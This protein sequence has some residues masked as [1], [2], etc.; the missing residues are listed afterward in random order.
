[1]KTKRLSKSALLLTLCWLVYS[2]SYI[3][4]LSYN[5]NINQIIEAF[6]VNNEQAGLVSSCFFF[7]YGIGQVVNG[8][9]CKKY[10]IKY[11]I[12][13]SLIVA[14]GMNVLAVTV[15]D[16]NLIKYIWLINGV[17]MSFLWTSLIRLLS[18]TVEKSMMPTVVLVM[19][20]TVAT[21]TFIV[22]GI[23]SM[24][25][26]LFSY[27]LTFYVAAGLMSAVALLWLLSYNPLVNPLRKERESEESAVEEAVIK[28]GSHEGAKI[29]YVSLLAALAL[30][31]VANNFVKDGLSAW[32]PKILNSLYDT[33][34]WLSILLTLL[35]PM[36]A[37]LGAFVA[38]RIYK[39]TKR[40]VLSCAILFGISAVLTG[41]VI[42]FL[43]TPLLPVTVACF[44]VVSLLM[45]GVNNIITSMAPLTLGANV[46]PGRLAGILNGF[47]YLGSTIS[48]WCLGAVS[49]AFDWM[50]VF[51]LLLAITCA[52]ALIGGVYTV[53]EKSKKNLSKNA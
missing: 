50:A 30:F 45:A 2:C 41:I 20:T 28:S 31:A 29:G 49:D 25:V 46:N 3:G 15:S 24:F 33:P 37:I 21:G 23:S 53:I 43:S 51:Y 35:L 44:G 7:A 32:T 1:M 18:E 38:M 47:C 16:L 4:K 17:A 12:F 10:N 8:I 6:G 14:S 27:Q 42:V 34:D 22:Y 11:V 19:G 36:L 13:I 26:A 40:Y 5:A 52:M 9:L 39:M 48:T